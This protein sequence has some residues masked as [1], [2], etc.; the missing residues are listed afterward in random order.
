GPA[1]RPASH[2]RAER[3]GAGRDDPDAA[4]APQRAAGGLQ[5]DSDS[6]ARR[7]QRSGGAAAAAAGGD[8]QPHPPL[9]L[10]APVRADPHRRLQLHR[11]AAV[12]SPRV[13]AAAF[14]DSFNR[15][16]VVSGMRPTGRLHLGHLVGAL[17]NWVPMQDTYDCFYF[18][19]DWHALT[20]DFANTAQ[21]TSY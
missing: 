3:V 9:R 15:P 8:V 10:P 6:A 20:S 2:R 14:T 1:D 16:R 18:V 19:A 7:R 13:V 5:H 11:R 12:P 4:D 21:L 17:S